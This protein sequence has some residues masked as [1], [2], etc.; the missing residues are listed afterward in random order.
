MRRSRGGTC[1]TA[2]GSRNSVGYRSEVHHLVNKERTRRGLPR[3]RWSREM[4]RLAQSQ[5]NYCARVGH[6]V[7]SNRC[8]FKGGEN[9]VGGQGSFTAKEVVKSWMHSKAGHREYL[10]SPRVRRV[11]IGVAK[12]HGKMFVAWAFSDEI[13]KTRYRHTLK[14]NA[15]LRTFLGISGAILIP[16]SPALS[17]MTSFSAFFGTTFGMLCFLGGFVGAIVSYWKRRFGGTLML[18]AGL[19]GLIVATRGTGVWAIVGSLLL[20]GCSVSAYWHRLN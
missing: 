17:H 4:A 13:G 7:H 20:I 14:T 12:R 6:M 10:L 18:L 2:I 1:L 5:A 9:L 11:G 3:V 8:A 16:A 19:L 15:L